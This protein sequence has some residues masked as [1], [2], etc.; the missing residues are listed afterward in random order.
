[1][2]RSRWGPLHCSN[3]HGHGGWHASRVSLV[4]CSSPVESGLSIERGVYQGA[5]TSWDQQ[6][7]QPTNR[8][9]YGAPCAQEHHLKPGNVSN[10][11]LSCRRETARRFLS[12]N[13]W[14]SHSRS[15]ETT[16]LSRACVSPYLYSIETMSVYRTVSEIFSVKNG[17][18]L[19]PGVGVVQGHS[20]WRRSIDYIRLSIGRPL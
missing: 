9:A 19:K 10:K 3:V 2:S 14:L 16:L 12:L 8:C 7:D 15:F 1:M 4:N 17:V 18:T 13:M 11:N 5:V 6:D 20:K